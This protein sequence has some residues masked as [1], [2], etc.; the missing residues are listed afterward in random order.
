VAGVFAPVDGGDVGEVAVGQVGI[1]AQEAGDGEQVLGPDGE[2]C[3]APVGGHIH[4]GGWVLA[5]YFF[6]GGGGGSALGG[7][8]HGRGSFGSARSWIF[9]PEIFCCRRVRA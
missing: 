3:L 8:G 5:A 4:N 6:D 2:S 1:V 7:G 9:S